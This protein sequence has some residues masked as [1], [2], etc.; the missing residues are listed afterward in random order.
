MGS[1]GGFGIE[2]KKQYKIKY[3]TEHR[4][5]KTIHGANI[6]KVTGIIVGILTTMIYYLAT[7]TQHLDG[8]I[9]QTQTMLQRAKN[10]LDAMTGTHN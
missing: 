5:L 2:L 1:F 4:I 9:T 3:I 6:D 7:Q 8:P 10:K